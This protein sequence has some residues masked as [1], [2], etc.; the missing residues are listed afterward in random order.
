MPRRE[1][2]HEIV[3]DCTLTLGHIL[4]TRLAKM[5]EGHKLDVSFELP[6]EETLAK[7]GKKEWLIS[8]VHVDTLRSQVFQSAKEPVTREED[9][10]GN[11]VEFRL[12]TPTYIQPRYLLTPWTGSTLDDQLLTG[13]VMQCFFD[14]VCIEP[15]EVQGGS[16]QSDEKPSIIL[17]EKFKI[18]DQFT[19]WAAQ[20]RRYKPSLMYSVNLRLD[21][22]KKVVI[23]RVKERVMD[24]RKMES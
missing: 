6:D 13:L 20:G 12:G 1:N 5:L 19:W 9:E 2:Q 21:S 15:E 17:E 14:H 3:R 8:L 18:D 10:E 23:K 22:I 7:V 16:I 11:I 24:F 4:K